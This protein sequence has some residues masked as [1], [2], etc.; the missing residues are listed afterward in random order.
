MPLYYSLA[1]E[2][3]E[4]GLPIC[5]AL[6]FEYPNDANTYDIE[7]EYLIGSNIL[8]APCTQPEMDILDGDIS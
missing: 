4:T 2:A 3:Y 1:R 5:R 6:S 8:F 7:N